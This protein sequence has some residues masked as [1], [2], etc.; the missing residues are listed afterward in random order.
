MPDIQGSSLSLVWV[1]PFVFLVAAMAVVPLVAGQLWERAQHLFI[2]GLV[3]VVLLAMSAAFVAVAP[4]VD[5]LRSRIRLYRRAVASSTILR[6]RELEVDDENVTIVATAIASRRGLDEPDRTCQL[7]AQ[8]GM[9]AF[10]FSLNQ[11]LDGPTATTLAEHIETDFRQLV[12]FVAT[13]KP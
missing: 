6:G 11:W 12:G 9:A 10:R 7:E 8:V 13:P 4:R 3:I 5:R 2:A 1:L